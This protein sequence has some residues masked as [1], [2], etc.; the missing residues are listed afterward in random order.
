MKE[1]EK[2]KN[3]Y[4]PIREVK[5]MLNKIGGYGLIPTNSFDEQTT[6]AIKDF[7]KK[8]GLKVNGI[9]NIQTL[10][11]LKATVNAPKKVEKKI[12]QKEEILEIDDFEIQD[13]VKIGIVDAV[14]L[15]I[16]TGAGY[17]FGNLPSCPI[18]NGGTKLE[19][20]EDIKDVKNELWYKVKIGADFGYV[21]AKFVKII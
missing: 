12:E 4:T 13:I 19:V 8:H 16:R 17:E 21:C 18:V 6:E 10:S 7:Q 5:Q 1:K 3:T 20:Y 15:N 11:K 2:E 14:K 9:V